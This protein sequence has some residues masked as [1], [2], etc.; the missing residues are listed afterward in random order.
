MVDVKDKDGNTVLDD[1]GNPIRR[2]FRKPKRVYPRTQTEKKIDQAGEVVQGNIFTEDMKDIGKII[3]HNREF[4]DSSSNAGRINS[5]FGER[6]PDM[7]D[8]GQ[9]MLLASDWFHH[10]GPSIEHPDGERGHSSHI[11]DENLHPL[12]K[13]E[14]EGIPVWSTMLRRHVEPDEKGQTQ[15]QRH[16]VFHQAFDIYYHMDLDNYMQLFREWLDHIL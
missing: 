14:A 6:L 10:N 8:E 2:P 1:E 7:E 9:R 5:V 3:Y 11:F 13:G 15:A 4:F 16:A 12:R